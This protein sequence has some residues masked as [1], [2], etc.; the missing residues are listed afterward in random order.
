MFFDT[1]AH[2][3]FNGFREDSNEVI[4]KSLEQGLYLINVGSQYSTSSRAVEFANK[5]EKGVYAAAGLHPIQLRTGNFVYEDEWE[6]TKEEIKTRGEKFIYDKYLDLA[7]NSKVVAIGEVG[8]DY[9]HFVEGDDIDAMKEK[10]GA[11]FF[12]FIKMAN[13]V[14][15][16]LI[17]HCWGVKSSKELDHARTDA[18]DELYETLKNSPAKKTGVIHNF[19]GSYKTARKFIELGYKIGLNG[20]ITYGISYDRLVKEIDLKDILIETDC[21]YLSPVPKKGERNEPILVKYVAQKIADIK[22]ISVEEVEKVTFEN[23][24]KLFDIK[25]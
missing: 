9:H 20:V 14:E 13:E 17:I 4:K 16:P 7:R 8:L 3:N 5:Y 24:I 18:Y 23:A 21:P 25:I 6:M 12:E 22:N 1:H 15:K 19:V 11:V 2:V 10:Q